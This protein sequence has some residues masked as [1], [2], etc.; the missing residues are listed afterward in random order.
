MHVE[1]DASLVRAGLPGVW[2]SRRRLLQCAF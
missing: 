1:A 2:G